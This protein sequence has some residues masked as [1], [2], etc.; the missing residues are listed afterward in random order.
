MSTNTIDPAP[1]EGAT[2]EVDAAP[3][4]TATAEVDAEPVDRPGDDDGTGAE[5][6]GADGEVFPRKVVEKLRRESATLRDRAKTA[7]DRLSAMQRQ[8]VERQITSAQMRPEAVWAVA[9]LDELV[10]D[11]GS[12]DAD[13]VTQAM[14]RAKRTL[15]IGGRRAPG[16]EIGGLSSG[17]TGAKDYTPGPGFAAAFRPRPR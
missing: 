10:A 9:K 15:G 8:S 1:V 13:A 12:V 7:E 5:D 16:L 3:V 6:D 17:A 4:E 2:P 14:A 11:D